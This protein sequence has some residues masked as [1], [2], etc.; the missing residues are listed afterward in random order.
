LRSIRGRRRLRIRRFDRSR[1]KSEI[2]QAGTLVLAKVRPHKTDRKESAG[3][4][5]ASSILAPRFR[6]SVAGEQEHLH[7]GGRRERLHH[8][9]ARGL[10]TD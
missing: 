1:V 7:H 4:L 3:T 6:W 2:R 8:G 9:S 10:D 5:N